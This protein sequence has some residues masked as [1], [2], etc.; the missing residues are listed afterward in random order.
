[1][2]CQGRQC[3]RLTLGAEFFL[4]EI[5]GEYSSHTFTDGFGQERHDYMLYDG[6][7]AGICQIQVHDARPRYPIGI[8]YTAE[9]F[10]EIG[11]FGL[12]FAVGVAVDTSR[13]DIRDIL[14][15]MF[16]LHFRLVMTVIAGPTG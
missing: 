14:F 13:C 7:T 3:P 15:G 16:F 9:N 12:I 11:S 10:H 1:M 5:C 6:S 8:E 2:R 4:A